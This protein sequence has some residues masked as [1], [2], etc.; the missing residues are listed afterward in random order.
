MKNYKVINNIPPRKWVEALPVGNGRMG[1]TFMGNVCREVVSLNEETVWGSKEQK[2]A[3]PQMPEKLKAIREL[4][5]KGKIAEANRLGES[6][7]GD[8]YSR[9]CSYEYAGNMLIAL[10]SADTSRN[11]HTEIDL[12]NGIAT[13]EYDLGDSH[14]KRE[15]FASYPD[16]VMV[17]R[18][19]VDGALYATTDGSLSL[20]I[21]DAL[22]LTME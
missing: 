1:A 15:A 2:G 14:Y 7:L 3:N 18:V 11:Y 6:S 9:I 19:T 5:L 4:F 21:S 22:T 13:V 17:Y 10:H 8:C 20:F 12:L 16:D